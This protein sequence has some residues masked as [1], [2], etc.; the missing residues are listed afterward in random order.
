M[1]FQTINNIERTPATPRDLSVFHPMTRLGHV[2]RETLELLV[3][4]RTV[5]AAASVEGC[6]DE[7][8]RNFGEPTVTAA[9][10]QIGCGCVVLGLVVSGVWVGWQFGIRSH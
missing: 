6:P 10:V 2:S 3:R 7:T 1:R 4:A 8:A 9:A 5:P